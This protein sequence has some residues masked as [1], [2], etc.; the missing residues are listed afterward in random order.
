MSDSV[1][2]GNVKSLRKAVAFIHADLNCQYKKAWLFKEGVGLFS[3][4]R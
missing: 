4:D 1:N 2:K 3:E